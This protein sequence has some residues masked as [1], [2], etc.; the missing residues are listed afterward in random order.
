[1]MEAFTDEWAAACCE[2]INR[3]EGYRA[4]AAQWEDPIVLL[5]RTV[6]A[7][8]GEP[9]R[10]FWLDLFHGSCRGVRRATAEDLDRAPFVLAAGPAVWRQVLSRQLDPIMALMTGKLKLDRG[11]LMTLAKHA[12]A[13]KQLVAAAS[14]VETSWPAEP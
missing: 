10:G 14:E 9:D 2:R 11:N 6:P 12:A 3:H 13:A 5:L 1:M 7:E 4:A 8:G